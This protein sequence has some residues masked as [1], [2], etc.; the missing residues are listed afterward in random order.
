V[1]REERAP[2]R[3]IGGRVGWRGRRR[4]RRGRGLTR[5]PPAD[6][7]PG[8]VVRRGALRQCLTWLRLPSTG[9]EGQPRWLPPSHLVPGA[10]ATRRAGAIL[11]NPRVVPVDA[12]LGLLCKLLPRGQPLIGQHTTAPGTAPPACL[13]SLADR[14]S[15][16]RATMSEP[17]GD[18]PAVNRIRYRCP[19]CVHRAAKAPT[20]KSRTAEGASA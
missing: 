16:G 1:S 13:T 3:R 5:A 14:T 11:L 6:R 2:S 7:R 20:V 9:G 4:G 18:R 12:K 17:P 10:S 8:F 19:A 15:T